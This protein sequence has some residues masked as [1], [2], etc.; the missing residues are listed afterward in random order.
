MPDSGGIEKAP[1]D[2]NAFL[3]DWGSEGTLPPPPKL[4]PSQELKLYR[5]VDRR[6]MPILCLMYLMASMDRGTQRYV[7]YQTSIHDIPRKHCEREY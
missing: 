2:N 1:N 5:K 3:S 6:L 7:Y 4:T